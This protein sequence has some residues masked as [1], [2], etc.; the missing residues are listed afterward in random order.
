MSLKNKVLLIGDRVAGADLRLH[1]YLNVNW[2]AVLNDRPPPAKR[3][4]TVAY[5]P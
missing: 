2:V 5:I 3:K 1:A 4:I